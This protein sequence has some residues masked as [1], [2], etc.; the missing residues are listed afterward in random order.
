M[1]FEQPQK[2]TDSTTPETLCEEGN[3]KWYGEDNCRKSKPQ[4]IPM[5]ASRRE[6]LNKEAY[7]GQSVEKIAKVYYNS[8][9][10]KGDDG[11]PDPRVQ[12]EV[13][14]ELEN[15][16]DSDADFFQAVEEAKAGHP[17]NIHSDPLTEGLDGQESDAY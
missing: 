10:Q 17:G 4:S 5:T 15:P 6:N 13:L 1:P 2:E 14:K 11:R 16:S 3:M 12:E 8:P 7:S 9:Y